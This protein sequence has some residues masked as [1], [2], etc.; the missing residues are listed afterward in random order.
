M[1]VLGGKNRLQRG[2]QVSI[3]A[4]IKMLYNQAGRR[5]GLRLLNFL[6]Q[7]VL[8]EDQLSCKC[9]QRRMCLCSFQTSVHSFA[10]SVSVFENERE[11]DI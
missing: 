2:R 1:C 8:A 10:I 3:A 4:S 11:E 5:T 9:S 6:V 7:G